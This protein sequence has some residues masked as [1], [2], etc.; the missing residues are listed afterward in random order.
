MAR[1]IAAKKLIV[2]LYDFAAD[3]GAIST[4]GMGIYIPDNSVIV[5][6]CVKTN[7]TL[8]SG[9]A[10]VVSYGWTGDTDA[11]LIVNAMSNFVATE[12]MQGRDFADTPVET[13]ASRE[14]AI[15]IAT[16]TVTAGVIIAMCEFI[17]LDI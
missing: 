8:T 1:L 16:A 6:F 9:G 11:L 12:T 15:T 17:E 2:A 10:S 3:G 4:I 14:I 7:T 5:N 13:T